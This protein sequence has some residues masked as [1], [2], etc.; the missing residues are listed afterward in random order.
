[1][2]GFAETDIEAALDAVLAEA[3]RNPEF[4]RRVIVELTRGRGAAE[5]DQQA[6]AFDP[7]EPNLEVAL[8]QNRDEALRAQLGDLSFAQLAKMVKAQRVAN[9]RPLFGGID[10]L[11]ATKERIVE[12]IIASVR[13]RI[14]SRFSAAS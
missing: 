4:A 10:G 5:P 14:K 9:V 11:P 13:A 7:Y 8:M 1:M 2:S 12:A 6:V 3:R